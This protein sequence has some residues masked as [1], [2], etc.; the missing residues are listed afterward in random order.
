M[1]NNRSRWFD[2][3]FRLLKMG[4]RDFSNPLIESTLISLK[5][6]E[7]N[8]S[9]RDFLIECLKN[10]LETN[11]AEL[12]FFRKFKRGKQRKATAMRDMNIAVFVCVKVKE[13]FERKDAINEAIIFSNSEFPEA[14]HDYKSVEAAYDK[15]KEEIIKEL[16]D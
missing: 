2:H 9:Q 16:F 10:L 15:H 5:R 13:G 4:F 12:S 1:F 6:D 3:T 14:P 11:N 8:D 7:L